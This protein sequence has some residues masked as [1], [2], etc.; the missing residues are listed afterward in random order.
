MVIF[1][2]YTFESKCN[3]FS[4]ISHKLGLFGLVNRLPTCSNQHNKSQFREI[5]RTC[6]GIPAMLLQKTAKMCVF[7][8]M[9]HLMYSSNPLGSQCEIFKECLLQ[10]V[11]T[12]KKGFEARPPKFKSINPTHYFML[13][14]WSNNVLPLNL[15]PVSACTRIPAPLAFNRAYTGVSPIHLKGIYF[16]V[17][18]HRAVLLNKG[19]PY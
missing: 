8:V 19:E 15:L 13:G 3:I 6:A 9:S 1:R 18:A 10:W 12:A 4:K 11:S 7:I 2:A 5:S 16:R 14:T 17:D